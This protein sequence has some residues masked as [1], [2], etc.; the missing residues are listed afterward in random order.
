MKVRAKIV[1]L[2]WLLPKLKPFPQVRSERRLKKRK[3]ALLDFSRRIFWIRRWNFTQIFWNHWPFKN[4]LLFDYR[5]KNAN[6]HFFSAA[7]NTRFD[8]TCGNG[9]NFVKN[10]FILTIFFARSFIVQQVNE[11]FKLILNQIKIVDS[12]AKCPFLLVQTKIILEK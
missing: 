3:F 1:H 4:C 5:R 9:F 12:R 8:I 6:F 2:N 11:K 10:E 7:C